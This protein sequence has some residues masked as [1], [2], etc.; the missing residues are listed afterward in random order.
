MEVENGPGVAR[1]WPVVTSCCQGKKRQSDKWQKREPA[2]NSFNYG[3]Y[4]KRLERPFPF[5]H[6]SRQWLWSLS[7][8]AESQISWTIRRRGNTVLTVNK[9]GPTDVQL[10][11]PRTIGWIWCNNLVFSCVIHVWRRISDASILLNNFTFRNKAR[12]FTE[13]W[14]MTAGRPV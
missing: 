2:L 9:M 5:S 7:L 3:L 13:C 4:S 11:V 1:T 10:V 6:L 14:V 8:P 12:I